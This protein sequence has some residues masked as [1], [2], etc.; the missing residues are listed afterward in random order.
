MAGKAD[1]AMHYD[2]DIKLFAEMLGPSL[3]YSCGNWEDTTNLDAAQDAKLAKLLHFAGAVQNETSIMD[4][5]CGWGSIPQ[6]LNRHNW[7]NTYTGI[8]ISDAQA[9]YATTHCTVN[10][11]M[12]RADC[13]D[14][15]NETHGQADCAVSI[16]AFEHFASPADYKKGVHIERYR[17]FF[18]LVHRN[19]NGGLGLQTIVV[20][21][22]MDP[23][24]TVGRTSVLRFLLH[25]S[26][27][28]FPNSLLPSVDDMMIA[29][30]SRYRIEEIDVHSDNYAKTCAAWLCRLE[31][32]KD[33]IEPKLFSQHATYLKLCIDH[34]NDGYLGLAQVS[35]TPKGPT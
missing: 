26:R 20:R 35:L 33:R 24:D 18:D 6:W 23:L 19:V 11:S 7:N 12:V 15:L 5:G 27:Y 30:E 10:Q 32:A 9:T 22:K 8:T 3:A 17:H 16:G 34:F 29:A 4:I 13:F 1:I 21:K 31:A 14:Y 2:E 25:I 28:I